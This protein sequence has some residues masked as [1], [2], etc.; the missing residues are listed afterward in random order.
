MIPYI[1]QKV[2]PAGREYLHHATQP[3]QPTQPA[4]STSQSFSNGVGELEGWILR[5]LTSLA[6]TPSW[7]NTVSLVNEHHQT[8]AHLAVL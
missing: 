5:F 4:D 1:L 3:V 2:S 7:E 6:D 8:L